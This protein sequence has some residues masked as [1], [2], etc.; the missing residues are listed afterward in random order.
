[1]IWFRANASI[2]SCCP[3]FAGVALLLAAIGIYGVMSYL[4][5]QR[6][7]E[8]GIRMALGAQRANVLRLV[9]GHAFRLTIAGVALGVALAF[10]L[11]RY[12]TT[13]L[14]GV[15]TR[16]AWTFCSVALL[17]MAVALAASYIPARRA[18]HVDPVNAL[19]CE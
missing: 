11:T 9:V 8:I 19:R 17:L 16:D 6:T 1:M 4:V 18:T 12:L 2:R 5:T 15:S 14:Y 10:A 13:L 3:S 7:Q